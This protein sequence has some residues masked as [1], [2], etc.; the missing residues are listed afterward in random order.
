MAKIN[1]R[2]KGASAE[3][4]LI[5][6]LTEHLGAEITGNMKRN[7]EQTRGGGH[8]LVGLEG[9]AIEVKRYKQVSEGDMARFWEQ[10]VTQAHK[11]MAKPVLAFREDFRSWRVVIPISVVEGTFGYENGLVPLDYTAEMS[12]AAYSYIVRESW[13]AP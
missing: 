3:R 5:G 10:T 11:V 2:A 9:W 13:V 1:S 4:E 12:V 6:V 7:L 8:D